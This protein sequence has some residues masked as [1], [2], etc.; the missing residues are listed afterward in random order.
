MQTISLLRM[1]EYP[2]IFVSAVLVKPFQNCLRQF[3][4]LRMKGGWKGDDEVSTHCRNPINRVFQ[5]LMKGE[6][7]KLSGW[8]G[9]F[10]IKMF[11]SFLNSS[12]KRDG[13]WISQ[14]KIIAYGTFSGYRFNKKDVKELRYITRRDAFIYPVCLDEKDDFNAL[15]R[16]PGEMTFIQTLDCE[17]KFCMA[18]KIQKAHNWL[19]VPCRYSSGYGA[20]GLL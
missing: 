14:G 16:F 18:W 6:R 2:L 7:K 17:K 15:N 13:W 11:Q 5:R 20:I 9:N 4:F 1:T 19:R 10:I 8:Y 12:G 3:P